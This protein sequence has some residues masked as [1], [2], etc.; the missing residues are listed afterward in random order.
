M[1]SRILL[2]VVWG[3]LASTGWCREF[4]ENFEFAN[5][6]ASFAF[7]SIECVGSDAVQLHIHE[8]QTYCSVTNISYLWIVQGKDGD[9]S[10]T[11]FDASTGEKLV[12]HKGERLMVGKTP[13]YMRC[14][15][16]DM[17]SALDGA[18]LPPEVEVPADY[19]K[20]GLLLVI[21][22]RGLCGFYYVDT[23]YIIDPARQV[24]YNLETKEEDVFFFPW[25]CG[26]VNS[27]CGYKTHGAPWWAM[28]IRSWQES[29]CWRAARAGLAET[30]SDGGT[31]RLAVVPC[32]REP[33]TLWALAQ[34]D[35]SR[36]IAARISARRELDVI[37]NGRTVAW[38]DLKPT[39]V[40]E[41]AARFDG[42]GRAELTVVRYYWS[43]GNPDEPKV[44][45][46][47]HY[48][49]DGE[50][51]RIYLRDTQEGEFVYAC[52]R[53]GRYEEWTDK[54]DVARFVREA[55]GYFDDVFGAGTLKKLASEVRKDKK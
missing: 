10:G 25:C 1:K 49:P 11:R 26:F 6:I 50:V 43:A 18:S 53:D 39:V 19:R 55:D 48:L 13:F 5:A 41:E 35:G 24:C 34:E 44:E 51:D 36:R 17:L 42:K 30:A 3:I 31:N 7:D 23:R 9:R 12:L 20:A 37:D 16:N 46:V 33:H 52:C 22:H 8:S 28:D 47:F 45:A 54:E 40:V 27:A 4:P 29:E 15:P 14:R 38:V 32:P 21:N 2:L